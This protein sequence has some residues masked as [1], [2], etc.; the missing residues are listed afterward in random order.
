MSDSTEVMIAGA[1][2]GGLTAALALLQRGFD[3]TVFEQA[4]ELKELGA[5]IQ[6]AANGS[7]VLIELGLEDELAP[8]V[9]DAAAKEVRIWNTGQRWK[10]FDLGQDSVR[11][12]GAP[13]WMVHRG[14]LHRVLYEAVKRLKPDAVVLNARAAGFTQGDGRV[15]LTLEDGRSFEADVLIG[16]DGVHSRLRSQMFSS[17]QA[18]FT[19]L[20]AWRG[21]APMD[22]LSPE[23]QRPV[24]TNWVGPGGHVITYPIRGNELLNFVGLTEN[25]EWKSESWT[26]AGT[27]EECKADFAGWHPLIH[28]IID[29]LDTPFRWALVEREPLPKWTEGRVTLLGDACH[30]TLPFL[31]QGAI[32]AI[33]DGLILARCLEAADDPEV[34]LQTYE[35]LRNERTAA[36]VRGS[37]ANLHRFHNQALADPVGAVEYVEREWEPEKVRMRYDWLFEYDATQLQI[38][39]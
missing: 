35:G 14:D 4:P 17:P 9:C 39:A 16:C 15:T 11:R 25:R 12:F 23:L 24:G 32:M 29:T 28:E 22:R 18:R 6:I 7:R 5:G 1:G 3:V 10:L 19:G 31:A 21:L 2:I 13:Y 26:E 27:I 36:I 8:I 38:S 37:Q 20:M 30:P 34:A 33:E